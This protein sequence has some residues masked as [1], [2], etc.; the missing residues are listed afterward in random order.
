MNADIVNLRQARKRRLRDE[1]AKKAEENRL[2]FGRTKSERNL[3][4]IL[5]RKQSRSLD[6]KRLDPDSGL[7]NDGPDDQ[8]D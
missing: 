7:A 2:A 3:T 5:N 4:E 8:S 1:K 6:Q